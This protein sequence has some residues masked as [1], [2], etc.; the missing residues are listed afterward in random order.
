MGDLGLCSWKWGLALDG[1]LSGS[2]GTSVIGHFNK[3]YL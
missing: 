3:S 2:G 1:I